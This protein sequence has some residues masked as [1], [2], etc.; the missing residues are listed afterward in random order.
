MSA[1][2]W[3]VMLDQ[4]LSTL[5]PWIFSSTLHSHD[6]LSTKVDRIEQCLSQNPVDLWELREL[7]LSRGG[8]M[9]C[10]FFQKESGR[11]RPQHSLIAVF[12]RTKKN[13][14]HY[15]YSKLI[16][17]TIHLS[18]IVISLILVHSSLPTKSMASFGRTFDFAFHG[19]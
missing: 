5:E 3:R 6:D 12:E 17:V 13:N 4:L 16:T 1:T 14:S 11:M 7:A 15:R 18:T 10:E 8:L 2:S 9:T 19:G